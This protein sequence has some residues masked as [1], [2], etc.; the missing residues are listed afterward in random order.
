LYIQ[1]NFLRLSVVSP[2]INRA[3]AS[4]GVHLKHPLYQV[5]ADNANFLHGC[6]LL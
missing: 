1:Y 5:L 2:N 6:S 4:S 3:I